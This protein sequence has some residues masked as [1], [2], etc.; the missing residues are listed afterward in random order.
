MTNTNVEITKNSADISVVDGP[1]W[2]WDLNRTVVV[3]PDAEIVHFCI[4]GA[5]SVYG[6]EPEDGI[7]DIPNLLLQQGKSIEC[8]A[9]DS[10]RTLA[11]ARL[12]VKVRAKPSDYLY[13]STE[14]ATVQSLIDAAL[15]DLSYED[16]N[17]LPILEGVT[18]IG[19]Q[20]VEDFGI[21]QLTEDEI[22][23]IVSNVL[24][25]TTEE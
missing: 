16:L 2:Q 7:A 25:S 18:I 11:H 19:S 22:A 10:E 9:S 3:P 5:Q 1:L 21:I 20:T 24:Y 15:E 17:D 6:V 4:T 8:W 13:T 14:I 23:E 12:S